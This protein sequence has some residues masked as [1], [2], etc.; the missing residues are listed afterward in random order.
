M[1]LSHSM[2]IEISHVSNPSNIKEITT[3]ILKQAKADRDFALRP[4]GPYKR[5]IAG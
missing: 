3:L 1:F 4:A 5:T 2:P